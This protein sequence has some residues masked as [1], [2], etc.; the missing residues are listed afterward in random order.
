MNEQ[1]CVSIKLH[2]WKL[3]FE[4]HKTSTDKKYSAFAYFHTFKLRKPSLMYS[5]YKIRQQ[6]GFGLWAVGHWFKV[7]ILKPVTTNIN[8]SYMEKQTNKP[9]HSEVSK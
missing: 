1:S 7:S 2:V 5:F 9:K 8:I 4:F 6:F 3:K